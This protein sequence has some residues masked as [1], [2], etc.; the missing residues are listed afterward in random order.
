MENKEEM[1]LV[2]PVCKEKEKEKRLIDVLSYALSEVRHREIRDLEDFKNLRGKRL[3]FAI[4]QGESGINLEYFRYLKELRL[5]TDLLEGSVGGIIVDGSSEL[6]TK[7]LARDFAFTANRAGCAFPGRP[8]VEGTVALQNFSIQA[9]NLETDNFGAYLAAARTLVEQVLSFEGPKRR[10][11][12]LLA[13][14]T[15][16][17]VTSNTRALWGLVKENLAGRCDITEISLRNGAISDCAGC[18]Y[19]MCLHFGEKE[20]CYYGGVIVEQVYPAILACDG[21]VMLCPNYNDAVSANQ[22]A[23]INRLTALFRKVQ[24]YD[25]YLF[26]IVVSGYSGGDLVA[27]QLISALNMNKT[28]ILPSRFAMLETANDPG[29]VLKIEGIRRRAKSF[30]EHILDTVALPQEETGADSRY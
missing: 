26:G 30:A 29:S 27:G 18:P 2:R 20:K 16:N 8:L 22:C 9:R 7:S 21:L 17:S 19:T 25:K 14:Q 4:Q 28:F 23:F 10:K 3:L 12:N 15:S 1:I 6:F 13:L 24:F 5:H 11:P